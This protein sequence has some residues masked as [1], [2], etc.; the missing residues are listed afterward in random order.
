MAR[1]CKTCKHAIFDERWGEWKCKRLKIVVEP[2]KYNRC[3][4]YGRDKEKTREKR[5]P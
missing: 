3:G 4:G 2:A 5:T 1:D